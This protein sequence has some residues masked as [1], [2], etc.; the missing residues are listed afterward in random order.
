MAA[1]P[2]IEENWALFLDLDGTLLDIAPAPDRV[3]VP[4]SLVTSLT[5]LRDRLQGALA[6]VSGRPFAEIDELLQP[7]LL[8]GGAEHGAFIRDAAGQ[9]RKNPEIH[10]IPDAWRRE[11]RSATRR[12]EGVEVEEKSQS[13]ALHFRQAP[14]LMEDVQLLAAT[15]VERDP[16]HFEVLGA[17]MAFEIRSRGTNKG[18][19]V[20]SLMGAA[21]FA[22]RVPVFVGD[23][24][25]DEDG[26][27]AARMLGGHGL[28]VAQAFEG[29]PANVRSWIA[30]GAATHV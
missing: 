27:L 18:S 11:L 12:W 23:D 8:S 7:A 29:D 15:I 21:P 19:V 6:I 20:V 22:G 5:T 14:E 25:T 13:V 24:V 9:M 3:V 26:I 28:H 10:D 30:A 4:D 17:K 16:A 2:K 1:T